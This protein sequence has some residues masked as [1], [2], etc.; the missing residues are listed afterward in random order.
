ML[1]AV[2]A[3]LVAVVVMPAVPGVQPMARVDRLHRAGITAIMLD[4]EE[5][6]LLTIS[7]GD[8]ITVTEEGTYTM[9]VEASEHAGSF[10]LHWETI[11]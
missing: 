8:T 4:S 5:E 2:V 10:E 6:K 1:V 11:E 7:D 9:Q 3:V